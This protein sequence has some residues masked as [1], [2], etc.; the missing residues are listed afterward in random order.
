MRRS[1]DPTTLNVWVQFLNSQ[2]HSCK[3]PH[4]LRYLALLHLA[5]TNQM[6]ALSYNLGEAKDGSLS[7]MPSRTKKAWLQ[8]PT[9]RA[10]LRIGLNLHRWRRPLAVRLEVLELAILIY[11][12]TVWLIRERCP[13]AG[14]SADIRIR[15]VLTSAI[16]RLSH[17]SSLSSRR[18]ASRYCHPPHTNVKG[19]TAFSFRNLCSA[20]SASKTC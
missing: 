6:G 14:S 9:P 18:F 15:S 7:P 13:E 19:S 16:R 4:R 11:V 5:A 1:T 3:T 12:V 2:I 8:S 17:P 10:R 20:G